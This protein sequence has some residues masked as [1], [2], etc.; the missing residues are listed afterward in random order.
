MTEN[1]ETNRIGKIF[2]WLA[3]IIALAILVFIFQDVLDKQY[4]PNSNPEMRLTDSGRAEVVLQQNRLGHYLV[5]G[6]INDQSVTFL[7]DTGAT[8]VSIP[9]HIADQL[10]LPSYGSYP[11]QTANGTVTVYQTKLEQLSIGNIFLYNVEAHINPGM[12]SDEILL[13]MSALKRVEFTQ[14]GKQLTLREQN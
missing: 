8:Q 9:A 7:L 12:K 6:G 5:Q 13:G 14:T 10:N 11:V 4:N 1:D 2:V 3:W